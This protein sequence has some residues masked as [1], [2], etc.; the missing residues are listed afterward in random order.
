VLGIYFDRYPGIKE[1]GGWGILISPLA[2]IQ[3]NLHFD[4]SFMGVQ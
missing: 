4:P 1:K 3:K 2:L